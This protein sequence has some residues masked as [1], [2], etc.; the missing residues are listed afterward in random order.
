M[1]AEMGQE[2]LVIGVERE[3]E[4]DEMRRFREN[5]GTQTPFP[6]KSCRRVFVRYRRDNK[7]F[8]GQPSATVGIPCV[9]VPRYATMHLGYR[10]E[11]GERDRVTPPGDRIW[12]SPLKT[13]T[14]PTVVEVLC[15][16]GVLDQ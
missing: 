13:L 2:S 12:A 16:Q 14:S 7:G 11:P 10:D 1:C 6:G 9:Y 5:V 4:N 3:P 15:S 8:A